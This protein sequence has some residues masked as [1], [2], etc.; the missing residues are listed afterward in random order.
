MDRT[1]IYTRFISSGLILMVLFCSC[2]APKQDDMNYRQY[3]LQDKKVVGKAGVLL[4][5]IGQPEN[6][7]FT[8]FKGYMNQIFKAAFPTILQPIIMADKGI[9]LL[10]PDNLEAEEK[11]KPQ[12]LMDCYGHTEGEDG[13]PYTQLEYEWVEPRDEDSAGHFLIKEKNDLVDITE[14]VSIKIAASYY[15]K[16]PGHKIPYMQQHRAIFNEV[17]ALLAKY[18]PGVPMR[19]GLAMYPETIEKAVDELIHEK[20]ETIVVCD[21]F[22]V[23]SSLEEFNSLF[24]EIKDAIAERAKVVF[25]PFIGAYPSYRQAFV[26]MAEDEILH[27]PKK[28]KKLL[29]LTRHGFPDI[30][31][32]PFPELGRV[33]YWN[34]KDEI[35]KALANTNTLVVF[36]DTDFAG[37]DSDPKK[38]KLA[39]F[40]ALEMGLE[41]QYD[42]IIFILVDF[43]SENTDTLFA[44]PSETFEHFHFKYESQVP[45]HDFTKPYRFEMREGKSRVVSA[46]TPVGDR[47]RP[48]VSQSVFDALATVLRQ[49]DWP[50]LILEEEK[51]KEALF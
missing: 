23:Y 21:F 24:E 2:S 45:Y 32:E 49:E 38:E 30:P 22:H 14:K 37:D 39:S 51:K 50:Q 29:V 8:F 48:F 42:H 9:V 1:E 10:D 28:E 20:V 35:E 26:R 19:W 17:E 33:F 40:E 18:F 47:Y 15:P 6:Y 16:M 34:L 31:G 27:L 7:D 43:L 13:I 46:G 3:L 12:T 41:E 36:A 4:T 25:T 44:H 11:F 5:A